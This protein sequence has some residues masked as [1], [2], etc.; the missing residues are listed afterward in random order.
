MVELYRRNMSSK[1]RHSTINAAKLAR[2]PRPTLMHWIRTGKISA[3]AVQLVGG[4]AVRLWT[5]AQVKEIR[6]LKGTLKPG[7]KKKVRPNGA[8]DDGG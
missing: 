1:P 4:M 5:D 3:P 6:D 7:P 8:H 2:V